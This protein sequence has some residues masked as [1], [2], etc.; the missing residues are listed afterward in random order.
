M[1]AS[2]LQFFSSLDR[3]RFVDD[4]YKTLA[5]V[6]R[7]LPIGYGQTIS[8]PSLVLYMTDQLQLEKTQKVLEIGTGSGY[9]T[10]F[11]AQF[12][13]EVYSVELL[14][15]LQCRAKERLDAL[16]Y[17]NIQYKLGDGNFGWAE[18]APFDRIM[19]GAAPR[20][21]PQT[22]IEQLAPQG[23]MIIPVGP[24]YWQELVKVTKDETGRVTEQKL[25]D[26]SFVELVEI[27]N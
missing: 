7:P 19:V 14:G 6:D 1:E 20:T 26:V 11:L 13:A 4:P 21:I 12:A 27:R 10:A 9:Q 16:G 15:Q 3:S 23:I 24:T 22:L 18:H 8:Q 25:L 5:Q 2:L 17:R